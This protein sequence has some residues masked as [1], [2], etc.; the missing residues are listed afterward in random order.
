WDFTLAANEKATITLL[1]AETAPVAGFYLTQVDP[2]TYD[3]NG[4]PKETIIYYSSTLDIE[5]TGGGTPPPVPEPAT[6]LLVGLGLAGL[7]GGRQ[8]LLARNKKS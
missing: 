3:A 7:L 6:L 8:R 5:D 2:D 1:L 4:E